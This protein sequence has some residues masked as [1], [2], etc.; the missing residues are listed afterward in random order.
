MTDQTGPIVVPDTRAEEAEP[1]GRSRTARARFRVPSFIVAIALIIGGGVLIAAPLGGASS[2]ASAAA[3]AQANA[4]RSAAADTAA[5]DAS[6]AAAE[7]ATA[8]EKTRKS[9][10]F[11]AQIAKADQSFIRFGPNDNSAQEDYDQ[12]VADINA[13]FQRAQDAVVD[14]KAKAGETATTAQY[15]AQLLADAQRAADAAA[16]TARTLSGVGIVLVVIGVVGG[17]AAFL[18]ARRRLAGNLR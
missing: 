4:D 9:A 15:D 6:T 1:I 11:E 2:T 12:A 13:D 8:A 14:A 10:M 16:Q 17:A 18:L 3:A 7:A 5:Q